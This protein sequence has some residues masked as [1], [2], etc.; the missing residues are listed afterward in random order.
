MPSSESNVP[1]YIGLSIFNMLC[2][3]LP[4]GIAAL[5]Y[6]CQVDTAYSSGNVNLAAQSSHMARTLNIIGIVLGVIMLSILIV[7]YVVV[8]TK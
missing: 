7:Y 4:L 3:C 2:C 1:S 6:S 5:I 8:S